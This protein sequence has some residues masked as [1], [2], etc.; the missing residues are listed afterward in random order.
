MM[1]AFF[2]GINTW[3]ITDVGMTADGYGGMGDG[4]LFWDHGCRDGR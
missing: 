1:V 3:R 2:E 4:N